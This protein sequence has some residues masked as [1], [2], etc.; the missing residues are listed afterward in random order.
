MNDLE[1]SRSGAGEPLVLIHGIGDTRA[2]WTTVVE[3]L[4]EQFEVFAV[5]LPGFGA[6]KA[7]PGS[8]SSTPAAFARVVASWMDAQNLRTAH[9]AGSSLGGWVAL[10]LAALGRARTVLGL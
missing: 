2:A 9:L 10:E 4:S 8:E 3:P 5:D 1:F 7:L 6:S